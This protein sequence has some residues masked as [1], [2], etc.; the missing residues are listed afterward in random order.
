MI[1]QC[2]QYNPKI[3]LILFKMGFFGAGH[4]WGG[5]GGVKRPPSLKPATH[6]LQ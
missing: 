5:G 6:I 4:G 3:N 2:R 1:A